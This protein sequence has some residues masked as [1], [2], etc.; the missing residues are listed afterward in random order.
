[1]NRTQVRLPFCDRFVTNILFVY[2][3]SVTI[4]RLRFLKSQ[5]SRTQHLITNVRNQ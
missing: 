5:N 1:M 3:D 4:L 2:V